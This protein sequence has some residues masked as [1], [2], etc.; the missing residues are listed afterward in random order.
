MSLAPAQR[1][2]FACPVP[3]SN[4]VFVNDRVWFQTEEKQRVV[5]VHGVVFAHYAV[6][7]RSAEAYAMVQLFE[8]GYAD[9]NLRL[10][11]R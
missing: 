11:K 1:E 10:R 4:T 5:F 7:D 3:T 8:S 9:Q 2:L 6:E